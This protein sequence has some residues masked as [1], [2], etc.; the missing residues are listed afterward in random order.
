MSSRQ[1]KKAALA[2]LRQRRSG[3]S[4][5]SSKLEEYEVADE[6]DVYDVVDEAEYEELVEKRRQRED[7]VVDD[8]MCRLLLLCVVCFCG[9]LCVFLCACAPYP[10]SP[11]LWEKVRMIM[12]MCDEMFIIF[13]PIELN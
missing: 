11:L 1:T 9:P 3:L 4:A 8:G 7:F 6:G 5:A 12:P 10:C 2:A 13:V